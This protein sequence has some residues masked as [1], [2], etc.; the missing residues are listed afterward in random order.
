M[1]LFQRASSKLEKIAEKIEQ[2][3]LSEENGVLI[4]I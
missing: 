4:E 2:I 3:I 1:A